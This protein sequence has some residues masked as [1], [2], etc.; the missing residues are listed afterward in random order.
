MSR[1]LIDVFASATLYLGPGQVLLRSR[2]SLH[3][4]TPA[5]PGWAGAMAALR[6]LLDNPKPRGRVAVVVSSHFAPL[7]LLP[8]APTRLNHEETR[9]WVDSQVT[10]RF[11]E[12]APN[13]CLAFRP[14]VSGEPILASGIDA[15][16]WAELLELLRQSGLTV[17]AATPW[18]AL[19]LARYGGRGTARLALVEQGRI[20][21]VSRERGVA[22]KLDSARG[23]PGALTD[24]L[25]RAALVDGLGDAPLELVGCGM[26]G[27]WS[28]ARVLANTH[29]I[30]L[31]TGHA[32]PD[33]LQTRPRTPL[34]AWLLLAVGLGLAVFYG[35]HYATLTE[36][37]AAI[38]LTVPAAPASLHTLR[39][40]A[41]SPAPVRPWGELL[42]RLETLRPESIALLSLQG[43]ALRGAVQIRAQARSEADMLDW[44]KTLRGEPGFRDASLTHHEVQEE[45]GRH[46]VSFELQLG[47]GTR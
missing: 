19:A 41:E 13:W 15:G 37:L 30:A 24:L 47:W 16:H 9:G 32:S 31:L 22:V 25:T 36:K 6:I 17:I 46:P 35:Q 5:E 33:F 34:V 23:E 29:D 18:P 14:A 1:S 2:G 40:V 26:A 3:A 20:T 4:A 44:L 10:E 7:W 39:V 27:D 8:G 11:G 38:S 12:L 43:D 21:L 45:E 28:G 42:D